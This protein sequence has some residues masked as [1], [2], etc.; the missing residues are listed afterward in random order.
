MAMTC[1]LE[2]VVEGALAASVAGNLRMMAAAADI[3]R[4]R[5]NLRVVRNCFVLERKD[6]ETVDPMREH[7]D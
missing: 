5:K 3:Q 7:M 2:E 4:E 6:L 1:C